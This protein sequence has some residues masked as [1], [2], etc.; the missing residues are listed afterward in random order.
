MY[1]SETPARAEPK[2]RD[3]DSLLMFHSRPDTA[4]APIDDQT[5]CRPSGRIMGMTL[6]KT[7]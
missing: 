5:S 3:E 4:A 1:A 2:E 6:L 7:L